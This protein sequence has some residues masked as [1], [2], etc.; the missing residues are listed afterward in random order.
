MLFRQ[1]A[2]R[3]SSMNIVF[4]GLPGSGK[5]TLISALTRYKNATIIGE[6]CDGI[7]GT[8]GDIDYFINNEKK[9]NEIMRTS[10]QNHICYVDRFWQSTLVT[11][12]VICGVKTKRELRELYNIIY[13]G[14]T[15]EE[16]IYV[17]L[18]IPS[19]ISL[20]RNKNSEEVRQ[21]MWFNNLFNK[22]AYNMYHL[23]YDNI[24]YILKRKVRKILIDT[25]KFSV[26]DEA[27]IINE[28][29]I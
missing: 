2:Y 24:D 13:K 11:N 27:R 28:L 1:M 17:F 25:Q 29:L 19:E 21:C 20:S 3:V 9:K 14:Y 23:L 22:K 12:A 8:L 5:S 16:Y 6:F 10:S 26:A 4:E 7:A 18:D 15:F